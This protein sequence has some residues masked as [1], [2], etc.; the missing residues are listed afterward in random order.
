[1]EVRRQKG[2]R[3]Q[4]V[5]ERRGKEQKEEDVRKRGEERR[6]VW[7]KYS[8]LQLIRTHTEP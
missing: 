8:S 3:D 5:V 2:G 1:M 4:G 7:Q 6:A